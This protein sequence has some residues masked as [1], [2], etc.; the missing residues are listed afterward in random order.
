MVLR[1]Q[2][3]ADRRLTVEEATVVCPKIASPSIPRIS[4]LGGRS[5]SMLTN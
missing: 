5:S 1:E 3:R 4:K 2:Q